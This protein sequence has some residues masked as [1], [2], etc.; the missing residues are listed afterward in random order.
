MEQHWI[1]AHSVLAYI[2]H[3]MCPD[4][5]ILE[6]TTMYMYMFMYNY[7]CTYMYTNSLVPSHIALTHGKIHLVT[8]GTEVGAGCELRSGM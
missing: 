2:Q 1:Y 8:L 5:Q 6:Y 7:R 4:K 3:E